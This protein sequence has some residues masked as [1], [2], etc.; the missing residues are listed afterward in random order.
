L[1]RR[2]RSPRQNAPGRTHEEYGQKFG[3]PLSEEELLLRMVLPADQVDGMLAAGPAPRWTPTGANRTAAPVTNIAEF[4]RAAHELPKWKYLAV[5]RG[6]EKI[7][8]RRAQNG[9]TA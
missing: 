8:L 3:R 4:I 7:E 1:P 9:E 2:R 5:S 6:T